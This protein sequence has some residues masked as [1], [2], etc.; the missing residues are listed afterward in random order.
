MLP[1]DGESDDLECDADGGRRPREHDER[2]LRLGELDPGTHGVVGLHPVLVVPDVDE[3]DRDRS[4]DVREDL[5][6]R[7]TAETHQIL[8][9]DVAGE[10]EDPSPEPEI[11]QH[12]ENDN[13]GDRDRERRASAPARI[14][15]RRESGPQ[16]ILVVHS[17]R[18][19]SRV[20]PGGSP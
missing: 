2:L 4:Q 17:R 14:R 9:R 5:L 15:Q 19:R 10:G 6:D 8:V 11:E 13:L 1:L 18:F 7:N 16:L 20:S 12:A 3:E